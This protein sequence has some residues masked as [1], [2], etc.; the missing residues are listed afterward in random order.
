MA[1]HKCPGA[2]DILM[3]T[4]KLKTCP[5]CGEEIELISSEFQAKCPECGFVIYNDVISCVQWCEYARECVGDEIYERLI[6][7]ADKQ[8]VK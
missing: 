6:K 7:Q 8:P 5:E 2:N 1:S 4:I 3:P